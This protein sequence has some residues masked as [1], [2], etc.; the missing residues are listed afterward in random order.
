MEKILVISNCQTVGLA[1]SL[2]LC[3]DNVFADACDIWQFRREPDIW[4]AKIPDYDYLVISP[5]IQNL[6]IVDFNNFDNVTWVPGFNFSAFHGDLTYAS[7]NGMQ[8]KTALDDYNSRI[9]LTAYKAGL[10]PN[11]VLKLF[12][13]E[14]FKKIGYLDL[15]EQSKAD[16]IEEYR[17]YGLDIRD[18][19][20]SWMRSCI[21]LHSINHPNINVV[22]DI[23]LLIAKKIGLNVRTH[24]FRPHD[25]LVNGAIFPVYPEIAEHYGF[26]NGSY[27]FK[28][29]SGF[30]TLSL[31][32]FV[33]DSYERYKAF[34]IESL[35]FSGIDGIYGD[36]VHKLIE[37]VRK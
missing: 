20:T 8:V 33:A 34:D 6:S 10:G 16:L 1:N 36:A 12:N 28:A 19:Y 27:F 30:Q 31:T 23:A 3:G 18:A 24:G 7:C 11:Q 26:D 13:I 9:I 25:N 32:E 29:F 4:K 2:S 21:F 15:Y 17:R 35:S 5:E 14:T 22:Y 37:D